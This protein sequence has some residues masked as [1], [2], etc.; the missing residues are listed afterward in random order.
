MSIAGT[1]ASL[2]LHP[3]IA[4]AP[5]Q[6][7]SE[8]YVEAGKGIAG[9]PRYFDRKNRNGEPSRRQVS[10][11]ARE[12]IADH[13]RALGGI[14]IPPGAVRANIETA[15]VDIML[16]LGS[17]VEIGGAVLY[18]CDARQ[19]CAKMDLVA[20]GLRALMANDRQGVMAQVVR[21]GRIGVG[22]SIRDYTA[23]AGNPVPTP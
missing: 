13:A 7:R 16:L 23:A 18:F 17:R 20:P 2:H 5:F 6:A 10:L 12:Q 9:N 22:D 19:P 21:S 1:V 15:G 8:I 11:I 14:D 3:V 4:G